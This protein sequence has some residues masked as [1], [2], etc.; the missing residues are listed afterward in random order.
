MPDTAREELLKS[1]PDLLGYPDDPDFANNVNKLREIPD[2]VLVIAFSDQLEDP[3]ASL[4]LGI[5]RAIGILE[6]GDG[7]G[8]LLKFADEPGKWFSNPDRAAIRLAA[9]ES[10]GIVGDESAA[11]LLLNLAGSSFDSELE[12]EAVRALGRIGALSSVGP[13]IESMNARPE[14]ALSAAGALMEIGGEEAFMG[15]LDGLLND[16]EMVRSASVWALGKFGDERA[17]A[18]LMTLT[19]N[20][21]PMIRRDIAW[22]LGEIGGFRARLTLG[23]IANTDPDVMVRREASKAIM[24]GAVLGNYRDKEAPED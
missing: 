6:I 18:R 24:N 11:E 8:L 5:M 17:I 22:A 19:E 10:I 16:K 2:V 12:M 23:A 14:I 7:L 15:L 4:A 9:V 20:S 13:L 21:D 1:I 3:D